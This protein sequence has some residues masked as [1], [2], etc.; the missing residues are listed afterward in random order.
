MAVLLGI[1]NWVHPL[2]QSPSCCKE[3]KEA[4]IDAIQL[5]LGSAE[6]GFPLSSPNVQR[7]WKEEAGLYGLRLDAVV[8]LA[9]L[10]HGMTAEPGSEGRATAEKAIAVAVDCAADMGIA[11]I[12]LPSFRASAI[13]NK[14]G[15][16]ET[17]RCLR[18]ACALAKHRGIAVAT[19]N[20]LD[21]T[22][23]KSLLDIVGYD[24]LRSCFDLSH[25]VLR[26][27]EDVFAELPEHLA[28]CCGVHLKDGMFGEPGTRP[29]GEGSCRAD[30]L[31]A[32][33]KQVGYGGTLFLENRYGEKAFGPD[34]LQALQRDAEYVRRAFL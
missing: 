4:G 31:L 28:V 16:R 15:L 3:L 11:Q 5:D 25:F 32:A 27:R 18:L 13:R 17:A 8:V 14:D 2:L 21:V 26:G 22:T 20:L 12:V 19:E 6:E 34:P 1:C 24:N 23:M 9:V 30:E 10:K 29:L 7:Q 33:L